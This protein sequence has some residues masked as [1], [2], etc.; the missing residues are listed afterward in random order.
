M[1]L[2]SAGV[3][4]MATGFS[5]SCIILALVY[6]TLITISGT[7]GAYPVILRAGVTGTVAIAFSCISSI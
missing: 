2:A 6:F 7:Q 5:I 1:V 3:F 4:E